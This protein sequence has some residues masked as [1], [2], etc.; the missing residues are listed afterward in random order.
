MR[1]RAER[2]P[3]SL[4]VVSMTAVLLFVGIA[5]AGVAGIVR[6]HRSAQ[7]AADLAAL[8]AASPGG[9]GCPA[10][11]AVAEANRA[12]LVTCAVT[13]PEARVVVRADGPSLAG[14]QVELMAEARAGP[15]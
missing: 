14:R 2:G 15:A 13:G 8:A 5:L 11:A 10:A 4:L 7:A 6:A 9:R 12:V 3:A 1:S